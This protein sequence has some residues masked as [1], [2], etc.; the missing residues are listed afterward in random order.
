MK[1]FLL[2]IISLFL[3]SPCFASSL[4]QVLQEYNRN[5][6]PIESNVEH[7]F[8]GRSYRQTLD[9]MLIEMFAAEYEEGTPAQRL[10]LQ[11]VIKC[12]ILNEFL[13]LHKL[14]RT[15]SQDEVIPPAVLEKV[16]YLTK[17]QKIQLKSA[18]ETDIK[19]I[20]LTGKCWSGEEYVITQ[21]LGDLQTADETFDWYSVTRA[22]PNEFFSSPRP[23]G[24]AELK[25][26]SK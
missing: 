7:R 3:M 18:L 17:N 1:R 14:G 4:D 19:I 23:L 16:Q 20:Y 6:T 22:I 11:R 25:K 10:L 15:P 24:D 8:S 2:I 12:N 21:F 13:L 26:Y 9:S 5:I